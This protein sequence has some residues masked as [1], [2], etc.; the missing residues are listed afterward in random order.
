[1]AVAAVFVDR[2]AQTRFFGV[3]TIIRYPYYSALVANIVR[4][5]AIVRRIGTPIVVD[6]AGVWCPSIA[7][8]ATTSTSQ[9]HIPVRGPLGTGDVFAQSRFSGGH[10]SADLTL[11]AGELQVRARVP[12]GPTS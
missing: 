5:P 4:D 12:N 11:Q 1:L 9:C 3:F 7:I 6:D 10:L 2:A 8:D